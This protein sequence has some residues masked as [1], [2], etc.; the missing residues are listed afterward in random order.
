MKMD[1]GLIEL[2]KV[3]MLVEVSTDDFSIQTLHRERNNN[4]NH[5]LES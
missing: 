3:V 5:T 4:K 1:E 2:V